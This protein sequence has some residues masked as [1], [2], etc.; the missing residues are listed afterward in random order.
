MAA[1]DLTHV[2]QTADRQWNW[3]RRTMNM[4]PN[5]LQ[6]HALATAAAHHDDAFDATIPEPYPSFVVERK[7]KVDW[8][9]FPACPECWRKV[10]PHRHP[11]PYR[12]NG[13]SAFAY[14][15]LL[16]CG[17]TCAGC[18]HYTESG[19]AIP[20]LFSDNPILRPTSNVE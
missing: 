20:M 8:D 9:Y 12:A 15:Y 3:M 16:D 1:I 4:G 2:A 7:Q 14:T 19:L 13:F 18:G 10:Y 6:A 11:I 5:P 17:A